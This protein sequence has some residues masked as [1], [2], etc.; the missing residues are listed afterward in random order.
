MIHLWRDSRTGEYGLKQLDQGDGTFAHYGM[1]ED[2]LKPP[3]IKDHGTMI[4]LLGN[5]PD[6][7]TMK[8]PEGVASPSRWIAKFL[9]STSFRFPNVVTVK[10]REGWT[11][12][13]TDTSTNILRSILG[14]EQYLSKHSVT[15]GKV[16]L[17]GAYAHWWILEDSEAMSQLSGSFESF[18]HIA[19]LR[20]DELYEMATGRAGMARLQQFGV[21]FGYKRVVIYVEPQSDAIGLLT[22]N[23]ARTQLLVNSE[24]LPWTDWATEFREN[25][26]QE[27]EELIASVAAGASSSDHSQSIRE[28]LKRII[29]LFKVSRYKPNPYGT[30]QIDD[31]AK[32]LGGEPNPQDSLP[33]STGNRPGNKGGTAGDIYAAFLKQGGVSGEQVKADVF[34]QVRWVSIKNGTRESGDIEDR[35]AKFLADQNLLLINEDFRV[36]TDMVNRWC[37]EYQGNP[38]VHEVV[39]DAV[40]SWFE[41]ALIETVIGIQSLQ[42]DQEWS[43][44]DVQKALS[45]EALTSA[46]MSRYHVNNSV[47]HELSSKLGKLQAG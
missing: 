5:S 9:N 25:I 6:A 16:K 36:F 37:Q 10:S 41:Q 42:N 3:I 29:D 47:K 35:A 23:T 34:P 18:G 19:A 1:I 32:G 12:L 38:A 8:A 22:T 45:E 4:V 2:A 40:H 33:R 27:I 17:S 20:K 39:S 44:N 7:D 31:Q 13:R 43:I 30:L 11:R 28:R 21:I 24:P 46:V 14:Q 26:P 15:S